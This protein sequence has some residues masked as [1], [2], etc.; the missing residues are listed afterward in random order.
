MPE[1]RVSI[2]EAAVAPSL[3]FLP[4]ALG[5]FGLSVRPVFISVGTLLGSKGLNKGKIGFFL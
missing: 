2:T 3:L 4:L 1:P 5:S